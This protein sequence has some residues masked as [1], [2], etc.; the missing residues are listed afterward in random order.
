MR[1][2]FILFLIVLSIAIAAMVSAG[3]TTLIVPT[4]NKTTSTDYVVPVI[5]TPTTGYKTV[6]API[7]SVP[8]ATPVSIGTLPAGT[9]V[10]EVYVA[11]AGQSVSY[12][13]STI[14]SG[15][16]AA[17]PFIPASNKVS[18]S[19]ST[20]TPAIYLIGTSAVATATILAR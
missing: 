6:A 11:T 4:G 3:D 10:V 17:Y 13:P 9:K 12:G 5:E 19:V 16:V 2:Y 15:T 7:V 14:S 20:T 18:F 1:R 8:V